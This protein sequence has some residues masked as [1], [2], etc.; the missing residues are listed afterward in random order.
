VLPNVRAG[1][2]TLTILSFQ[3]SWNEFAFY[4]VANTN[5]DH[6][7]LTT[8]LANMAAGGIGRATEYPLNMGASLIAT[9][10]VAILFFAFQRHF[11]RTDTGAAV[12][13]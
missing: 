11:V 1:L 8:G 4:E 13:G 9:I 2:I 7:T 6:F 3:S 12:K 5:P 10:P